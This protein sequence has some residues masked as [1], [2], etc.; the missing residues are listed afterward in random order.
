MLLRRHEFYTQILQLADALL[1]CVA[2]WIAYALRVYCLPKI[3]FIDLIEIQSFESYLWLFSI[4]PPLGLI[5]LRRQG[6][7]NLSLPVSFPHYL[8]RVARGVLLLMTVLLFL[9]F[10]LRFPQE[11]ISRG[12]ILLYIPVAIAA[13]GCREG[14]YR[15]WMQKKGRK[16]STKEHVL[17]IGTAKDCEVWQQNLRK[18]PGEQLL[19]K[20]SLDLRNTDIPE[21]IRI[22]HEESIDIVVL[23]LDHTLM[24]E[25]RQAIS[26]CEMEG[27]EVWV[28]T[29]FLRTSLARVQFDE[30]MGK[31]LLVYRTT[32]N[33]SGQLLAKHLLDLFLA[34]ALLILLAPLILLVA[35]AIF[36]VSGKPLIF[37]QQR[38]GLHGR[39]FTMYKFRTMETNA[40]QLQSELQIHNLMSGPVFKMEAD[41]RI[42][43]F[44]DFLRRYS[45]DELPQLWNV[46]RGE[47]SLVGPRPLPLYET[48]NF[49]NLAQ[50]RRMSV[51]PGLTCLW[52]ISGRNQIRDFSEWVRLDLEYIDHWSFWLD[53]EIL[54]KT[55]PAVF[56]ARGS[57]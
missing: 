25:S 28:T 10:V 18:S 38:S 34:L 15:I 31:P 42:T 14:I 20:S 45:L 41:P 22:L 21:F 53:L 44:G 51:K 50:R 52:Q 1:L 13:I 12:V 33:S 37:S 30:F 40:E 27:V 5:L 3:S 26:V 8:M 35:I 47:M 48:N 6:L 24:S 46:L 57:K 19:V 17:L 23:S 32:E 2:F 9:L 4:L 56:L 11:A 16:E 54:I 29:D 55:I 39:P 49:N 43:P 7:Y 36:F